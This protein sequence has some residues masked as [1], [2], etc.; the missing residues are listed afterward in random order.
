MLASL[1]E[2]E[3]VRVSI[4]V[5]GSSTISAGFAAKNIAD[6]ASAMSYRAGLELKQ[7]DL[8]AR[9]RGN[10]GIDIDVVWNLTLAANV[11]SANVRR[12]DIEA[13][14]TVPGVVDVFE[15]TLYTVDAIEST[16]N[17][18]MA[19]SPA[20]TGSTVAWAGG[21][22]GASTPAWILSTSLSTATRFS[23]PTM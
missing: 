17:P 3:Y 20:L 5:E 6:N 16:V 11:I 19:N 23:I 15:E 21:Y 10:L 4:V 22:T 13:I 2:D 14:K 1:D 7:E 9:I 18:N 12:G 8:V